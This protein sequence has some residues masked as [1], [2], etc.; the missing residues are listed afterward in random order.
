[1]PSWFGF[2]VRPPLN[3]EARLTVKALAGVRITKD[4]SRLWAGINCAWMVEKLC[5]SFGVK[6]VPFERPDQL[7][8]QPYTT[9]P[10]V[11]E[12]RERVSGLEQS[13]PDY[14]L[15]WQKDLVL[16]HGH[17]DGVQLWWLPG[18]AKTVGAILWALLEPGLIIFVTRSAARRTIAA[19]IKRFTIAPYFI[20]EGRTTQAIPPDARF[21][22]TGWDTLADH[23]DA[24][25]SLMPTTV[26]FDEIHRGKQSKRRVAVPKR[27]ENGEPIFNLQG[28]IEYDYIARGN[29]ASA[30][31]TLSKAA[32]R[33]IG[34]TASPV[35][36][37][38]RDLWAQLDLVEPGMWGNYAEW[39]KRYCG[40]YEGPFGGLQTGGRAAQ[41]YI[42]ELLARLS[43]SVSQVPYAVT[44]GHLPP[45]RRQVTYISREDLLKDEGAE[46]RQAVAEAAKH[47]RA[48]GGH[49]LAAAQLAAA[50]ARKR[51]AI[52]DILV[53][54]EMGPTTKVVI[55]T[56]LRKEA[57]KLHAAIRKRLDDKVE[58]WFGTGSHT[59][60]QRDA[61]REAFMSSPG[62]CVLVGTSE[63]WGESLNLQDTDLALI[64]MLPYTPGQVA[65]ME[66]RFSRQGQ[67]RPVRIRYLI[68]EGTYDEH[69]AQMLLDK[70]PSVEKV[71]GDDEMKGFGVAL[72][73]I[74]NEDKLVEGFLAK[75]LAS[76]VSV[77]GEEDE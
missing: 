40:A 26:V 19:D 60:Q 77:D 2:R 5:A 49:S 59:V 67:K 47:A 74:E 41:P 52:V 10:R 13:Y 39:T 15:P 32:K 12:M 51:S 18:A 71:V 38:L 3:P 44:H 56:G 33:R 27:G 46:A 64:A 61:M 8:R 70:L 6:L 23:A 53:E 7:K 54:E 68:G 76:D 65:Q 9:F 66:G 1:M 17:K 24:L 42:D 50:A 37:R 45:K 14:L 43:F 20:L 30:A 73:G 62:P 69:V 25:A 34:A 22:I 55:L 35:K 63:A 4:G 58:T 72:G 75:I 57:E 48:D 28:Q 29:M 16:S 21:V 36:D 11:Y 31:E